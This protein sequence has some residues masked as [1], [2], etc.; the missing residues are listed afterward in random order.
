MA[1]IMSEVLGRAIKF[2]T[3]SGAAYKASLLGHG[4][5]EA[6]AQSHV[7]MHAAIDNGL[8]AGERRSAETTTPTTFRQWFVEVLKPAFHS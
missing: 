3:I 8:Y 6:M 1:A 2:Q 7:D 5:S 4:A